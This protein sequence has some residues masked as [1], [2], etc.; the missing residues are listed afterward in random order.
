MILVDTSVLIGFLKGHNDEKTRLFD[1]ILSGEI[2]FGFSPY[3]YQEVLQ[4]AKN[5]GE[6]ERLR[7]Y[8]STQIFYHLP[9][10]IT[11]YEKAAKLYF[12]LR[13]KGVTPRSTIDILIALTAMEYKL[14]L[15]HNDRDFDL[16]AA[17]LDALNVLDM[18]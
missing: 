13:R 1:K 15:L 11:T 5:E 2:P 6:Y 10:K 14:M 8:L 12:D 9:E 18:I 16:M 17:H 4:G 7:D 3:T